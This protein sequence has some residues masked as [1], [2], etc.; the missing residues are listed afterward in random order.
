MIES[1]AKITV[2][3][4]DAGVVITIYPQLELWQK[5]ILRAWLIIWTIVGMLAIMS[6]LKQGVG[7]Q[8]IY[9]LVFTAFW[10]Y[11]IYYA[12]RSIVWHQS[13]REY[14]RITNETLDY[15]RSWGVYGRAQSFDLN[16]IKNLGLVNLEGKSFAKSYQNAFWTVGGEQIGF[17]YLGRKVVLGLRLNEKDAKTIV[18]MIKVK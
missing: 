1:N 3:N 6:M 7:E 16:T 9:T 15:K 8:L 12:G 2:D 18:K 13:G 11:F 10:L 14:L 5:W 17:E 4:T